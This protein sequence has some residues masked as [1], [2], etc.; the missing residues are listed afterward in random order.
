MTTRYVMTLAAI[1]AIAGRAANMV[2]VFY[3][4]HLGASPLVIGL[5]GATF[6]VLPMLLS[7]PAGRL[8]DRIGARGPLMVAAVGCGVGMLIPWLAPGLAAMFI[9]AG[10]IGLSLTMVVP[11]QNLV[12]V[13]STPQNR[14]RNLSNFSLMMAI[15][16]FL[17]PVVGGMAVDYAGAALACLYLSALAA[18]MIGMLV[19]GA[20]ALPR[21]GAAQARAS[22]G[23][24]AMLREP[25]VRRVLAT[26]SL[27]NVGRD[28]YQFYFPAYAHAN[29]VSASLIGTLMAVNFA[30]EFI[31]RLLLPRLIARFKEERLLAYAFFVG[32]AGLALLPL[33]HHTA[34]LAVVSF[35]FGLG[36]GCGQPIIT[37]LMFNYSPP[38][39]TGE[40]LGLRMT[41]IHLT[42][43][44]GPVT[45]GS[46]GTALGLWPMFWLNALIMAAGGLLSRPARKSAAAKD[47][48]P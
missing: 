1:S 13:I 24:L 23:V 11:L 22:G 15:G 4:L 38:G 12:G 5:L 43:L 34:M 8:A 16:N 3:A 47:D 26:S 28:I 17:G 9:A 44:I 42:K 18:T 33:A 14:A 39:R 40:A 6:A 30:A 48:P 45:F 46:I 32:A 2:L 31:M 10:L 7:M 36:M 20:R 29:G 35:I 27:I 19:F 25:L 41:I 21:G 37:I